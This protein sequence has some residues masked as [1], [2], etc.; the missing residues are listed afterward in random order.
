MVVGVVPEVAGS[1][2]GTVVS[3]GNAGEPDM[4]NGAGPSMPLTTEPGPCRPIMAST[5]APNTNPTP[6]TVV[7]LVKTVALPRVPNAVWLPLPPKA[8]AMSPPLPCCR[9]TTS[10]SMRQ[11]N[12]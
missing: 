2:S 10:S 11:T 7:A 3:N 1:S 6:S 12:T 9:R 4:S 8:L 5:S